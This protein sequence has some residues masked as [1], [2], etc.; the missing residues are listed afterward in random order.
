ML[1]KVAG[2]EGT[3]F[4][5][6]VILSPGSSFVV[7]QTPGLFNY[8]KT[9]VIFSAGFM[10]VFRS[11]CPKAPELIQNFNPVDIWGCLEGH[12]K[13]SHILKFKTCYA[14]ALKIPLNSSAWLPLL[15]ASRVWTLKVT[16]M[17]ASKLLLFT[18]E[19]VGGCS[20][21]LS[22]SW[23]SQIWLALTW[24]HTGESVQILPCLFPA[25]PLSPSPLQSPLW[26]IKG[27]NASEVAFKNSW[28]QSA[29][30]G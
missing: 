17:S 20:N 24:G 29:A 11:L 22:Q 18:R 1:W 10:W 9:P 14:R 2:R 26:A 3:I 8:L 25:T 23:L 15:T 28:K 21:F 4:R 30:R 27:L 5:L 16:S 7:H 19:K 13:M 6:N 12:L